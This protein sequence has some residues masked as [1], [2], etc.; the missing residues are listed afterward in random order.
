VKKVPERI[1]E[2]FPKYE[3]DN[4]RISVEVSATVLLSKGVVEVTLK[5]RREEE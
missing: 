3:I 5:K 2:R 1:K 4:I